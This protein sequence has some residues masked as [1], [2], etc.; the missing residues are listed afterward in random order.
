MW[1]NWVFDYVWFTEYQSPMEIND[2][3]DRAPFGDLTNHTNEGAESESNLQPATNS[4]VQRKRERERTR[5]AAMSQE[6]KNAKNMRRRE[7]RQK[8]K[9]VARISF[10]RCYKYITCNLDGSIFQCCY[11]LVGPFNTSIC[12]VTLTHV[13]LPWF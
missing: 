3:Q 10:L 2:S 7:A 12:F 5:Y 1:L 4:T 9:G 13:Y 6:E 8:K 11:K